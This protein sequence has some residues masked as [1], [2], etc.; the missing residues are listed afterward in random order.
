VIFAVLI[1]HFFLRITGVYGRNAMII[2]AFIVALMMVG[3]LGYLNAYSNM[4]GG[5]SATQETPRTD[6]ASGA[7]GT[8]SI[9]ALFSKPTDTAPGATAAVTPVSDGFSLGLPRLSVTSLADADLWFWMAFATGIF[10][11]V[12]TVA[13]LYMLT[14]ENNVRNLHIARD[15]RHRQ[16]QF[17]QLHLLQLADRRGGAP[18]QASAE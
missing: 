7:G 16:R 10:F 5:T 14:V 2:A 17:A 13:A 18:A 15:Y 9:D 8:T 6:G 11:I 3:G 1:V 12:T 4:A